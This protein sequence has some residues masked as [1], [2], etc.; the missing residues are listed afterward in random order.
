MNL[1]RDPEFTFRF[2]DDRLVG[3]FHLTE[4]AVGTRVRV[5]HWPSGEELACGV[6]DKDGWVELASALTVRAGEG[7][8]VREEESGS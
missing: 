5:R 3:R 6:V 4:V 7:F 2:A 8:T 1:Y